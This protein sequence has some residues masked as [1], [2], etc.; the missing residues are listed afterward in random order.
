MPPPTT[1]TPTDR[2]R[3]GFTKAETL[4]EHRRLADLAGQHRPDDKMERVAAMS[5]RAREAY[6][7]ASPAAR[8]AY[9]IF[10]AQRDAHDALNK[11]NPS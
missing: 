5:P 3:S 6:L 4:M 1:P 10:A 8:I 7:A 9:G 11:E 2:L